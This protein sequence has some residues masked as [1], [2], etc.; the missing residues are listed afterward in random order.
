MNDVLDFI[1]IDDLINALEKTLYLKKNLIINIGYGKSY[2]Q[3][4]IFNLLKKK[5]VNYNK[6]FYSDNKNFRVVKSDNSL[7]KRKLNWKPNINV[8]DYAKK[9][10]NS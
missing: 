2:S 7:A 10:N 3:K 8:L 5:K 6:N 9:V 4:T 1:H